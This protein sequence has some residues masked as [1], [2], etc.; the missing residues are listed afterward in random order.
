MSNRGTC[1]SLAL[2]AACVWAPA[3]SGTGLTESDAL[4]RLRADTNLPVPA[5]DLKIVGITDG[6]SERIVKVDFA[7]TVANVRFRRF[8]QRWTPEQF[9][10]I[11]G[12]WVGLS[13]GF[14]MLTDSDEKAANSYLRSLVS[15][16]LTYASACG[17]GFY[18][19]T[20]TALT[21]P[22]KGE[23]IGFA[24]DDLKPSAGNDFAER[25]NYRIE[26]NTPPSA[27]SPAS[28]NGVPAGV[29][30]E[31][32]SATATRKRGYRGNSF[33]V[34]AEGHITAVQ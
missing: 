11:G 29:S 6:E 1:L 22:P 14:A 30:G 19:P 27:R 8:D 28:C 16:Q 13:A 20:L 32:W 4:E 5:E 24:P 17:F 10:T 33:N 9:E 2:A 21:T 15:A 25:A 26:L 18:A 31:T 7:G 12:G 34:N 23:S 3:C